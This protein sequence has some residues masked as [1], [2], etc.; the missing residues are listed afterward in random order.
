MNFQH[1]VVA[2]LLTLA[3]VVSIAAIFAF[4]QSRRK[5]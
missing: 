3:G 4:F 5:P 2:M 1:Q